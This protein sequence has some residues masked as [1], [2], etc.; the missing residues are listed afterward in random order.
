[1]PHGDRVTDACKGGT[2]PVPA[3]RRR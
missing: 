3:S 1:V 2:C